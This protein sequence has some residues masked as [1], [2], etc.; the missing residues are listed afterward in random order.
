MYVFGEIDKSSTVIE[1]NVVNYTQNLSSSM[2]GINTVKIISGSFN[3]NYWQSLNVLFFTSG[4]P[5]YNNESKFTSPSSNYL[6]NLRAGKQHSNKY[7][8]FPSSSLI[9]VP[10]VYYAERIKEKSFTL[11][12]NTKHSTVTIKDDGF[13]N[14]FPVNNT[15]SHS[16]N[17]PSS[18]DNYV[19]NIFYDKGLV[20]I[21]ETSSYSHTASTASITI[22]T[23]DTGPSVN[24]FFIT[25]SDLTTSIK[26][27][28]TGSSETD[29]LTIKF[30][31]SASTSDITAASASKKINEVFNGTHITSS[32]NGS[33]ITLTND[34]QLLKGK[35]TTN[36][37]N[38]LPPISGAGAFN[39]T[40]GFGGGSASINYS[41]IL[42]TNYSMTFDSVDVITTHEYNVNILPQEYNQTMNY[43]VRNELLGSSQPFSL[44]T[45]YL[46]S[47]FTGSDFQPY[48]TT[49]NLYQKDDYDTPVIQAK[50]PKPIRK[51]DKINMRFKIKLDI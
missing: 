39:T 20:L 15:I 10:S 29:T 17:S 49:I 44:S 3:N 23:P 41:D 50:L 31:E 1:N 46:A 9:N 22:G 5:S 34:A 51:S 7:H 26:F 21:T 19:G 8:G 11:T 18:S 14:L 48:I 47:T 27:V 6:L 43:G 2:S 36:D 37:N 45:R 24:H 16:S 25:A 13:G 35:I 32:N 28:S 33:V 42:E 38:D 4:S 30:F 12:D 40:T